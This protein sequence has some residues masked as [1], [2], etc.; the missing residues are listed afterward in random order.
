MDKILDKTLRLLG[1]SDL[2]TRF[3]LVCFSQGPLTIPEIAHKSKISRSTAY[4]LAKNLIS[5][6]LILTDQK[7]H[8]AKLHTVE[9]KKLLQLVADR[10]RR[11]RRQELEI[12][13]NLGNLQSVYST[14]QIQPKV[15]L[16]EGHSGLL[17]VWRDILSTSTE[18]LLWTNQQT[19][20]LFFGDTNHLKFIAE[21]LRKNI[22]I[23]VLATDTPQ[24]DELKGLDSKCLRHT[25]ILP[26]S[27]NFSA[28][29]YI[30]NHKIAMLD[31]NKDII[32]VV[33]ESKPIS[34]FHRANFELVWQLIG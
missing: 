34:S 3:F 27:T 13:D 24:A 33:I 11:F 30:Y 8:S 4:L 19:E 2:E 1:C 14:T 21:R 5:Q 31:Y 18:V 25:K 10:Q 22:P 32:G 23:R 6:G 7:T 28:E 9:P 26:P 17:S 12:E 15:R 16:Y 20:N 29:T